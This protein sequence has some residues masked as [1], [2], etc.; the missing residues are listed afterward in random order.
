MENSRLLT[1]ENGDD[2][3][4]KYIIYVQRRNVS[5]QINS[6]LFFYCS[7]VT[8]WITRDCTKAKPMCSTPGPIFYVEKDKPIDV[9]WVYNIKDN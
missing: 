5:S 1:Q 4:D 3:I 9:A 7:M 6:N 2:G 8:D